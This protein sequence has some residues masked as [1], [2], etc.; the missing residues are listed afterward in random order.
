VER[1]EACFQWL[2]ARKLPHD[3]SFLPNDM[4]M[5]ETMLQDAYRSFSNSGNLA[6]KLATETAEL[7][8]AKIELA[9]A[10]A[11]ATAAKAEATA[12]K[13]ELIAIKASTSWRL[14]RPLRQLRIA[15]RLAWRRVVRPRDSVGPTMTA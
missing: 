1:A 5:I 2:R 4:G 13:A 6:Q 11:E 14:T 10:Q 12:A 8:A 7:A 3:V 9:A 15:V